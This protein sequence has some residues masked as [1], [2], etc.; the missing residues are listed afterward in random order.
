M[1]QHVPP[2]QIKQVW[3]MVEEG[4]QKLL[5]KH[6]DVWTPRDVFRRLNDP[7]S[8][9]ALFVCEDGFFTVER[10][11]ER[12]SG[13]LY[14]HI[15]HMWFRPGTAEPRMDAL[16]EQLDALQ[17]SMGAEYTTFASPFI[18]WGKALEGRF[19]LKAYVW[20]RG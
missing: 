18:G 7:Q 11:F 14:M 2:G 3:P 13:E 12:N 15:W 10:C 20:G 6:P 4:L 17:Q 8:A 19:T 9:I 1:L 16:I 5:D